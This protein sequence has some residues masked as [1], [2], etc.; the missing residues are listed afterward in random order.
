MSSSNLKVVSSDVGVTMDFN[1]IGL[2]NTL[3]EGY[4]S[5]ESLSAAVDGKDFSDT[6]VHS[7][8]TV[9]ETSVDA[10]RFESV[11]EGVKRLKEIV[12]YYFNDDIEQLWKYLKTNSEI[13]CEVYVTA[14]ETFEGDIRFRK[15][16]MSFDEDGSVITWEGS[17]KKDKD[18]R[19]CLELREETRGLISDLEIAS[20]EV[21]EE[22]LILKKSC[23]DNNLP[24]L[25]ELTLEGSTEVH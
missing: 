4:E 17:A 15:N 25:S 19:F 8:E 22:Y 16:E 24:S 11:S 10:R 14:T 9:F 20:A 6:G 21:Q 23:R 1:S 12:S 18:Y 2:L 3:L 13:E 5:V 7:L